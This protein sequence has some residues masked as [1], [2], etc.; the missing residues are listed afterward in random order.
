[1][2]VKEVSGNLIAKGLKLG[3]IVSRFND[4]LS[5][6]LLSGA[7]DCFVRHGGADKDITVVWVPGANETPMAAQKMAQSGKFD[8]LVAVGAVIQGATPHAELINSQV[9]RSLAKVAMDNNLPVL[10]GVVCASN[11]E[12]AIERCGTKAGNKGWHSVLAAIEMA[13]LY[14]EMAS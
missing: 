10:N 4:F 11:L 9:S 7:I 14:K 8:V 1:M 6:Q 2:N 13:N 5:K 3:V 12:Q